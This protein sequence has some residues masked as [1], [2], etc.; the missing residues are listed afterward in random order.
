MENSFFRVQQ[1]KDGR[2]FFVDPSGKP[3]LSIGLNHADESNLKYDFNAS[4]WDRKY[5]SRASWIQNGVVKDFQKFG[6]NTIGWTQEYIGGDWGKALDWHGEPIDLQHSLFPWSAEELKSTGMPYVVQLRVMEFE[7]WNGNP[8]FHDVF[9]EKFE[10]WCKYLARSVC[11]QHKDSTNLLGYYFVDI[12]AWI[13]HASGADFP[14]LKDLSNS[15][16][17][18]KVGE[19]AEKYYAT[20]VGA[21]KEQDPNHLILGD[22]YNGNKGIPEAVLHAMSKYVDVL[23]VQYFVEAPTPV[24]REK[25]RHDLET[26][27]QQCGGKPVLLA[28]IGNFCCTEK[29]PKRTSAINGQR[30]RGE[31]Y[32]A[33][34]AGVLQEKWFVGWHWCSYIENVARGWGIKD[35]YDEP[36]TELTDQM[37]TF[38]NSATDKWLQR[39]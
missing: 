5:G 38:N 2:W 6:F 17:A 18:K 33:S 20:I 32:V 35:P 22:R 26:F 8:I 23:S 29:N 28:D 4:I 7:D 34:L 19:I 14:Q 21:I 36:Y 27:S 12:P 1:D 10:V 39:S 16:R 15:E 37:T 24:A 9:S 13:R 11:S 31:D 3:F 30:E 25:M